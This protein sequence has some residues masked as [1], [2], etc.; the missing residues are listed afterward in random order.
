MKKKNIA[1]PPSNANLLV[2]QYKEDALR[3]E[4]SSPAHFRIQGVSPERDGGGGEGRTKEIL[5]SNLGFLISKDIKIALLVQE[6][7]QFC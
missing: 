5:R 1:P 7:W 3:P 4:L 2:F 6:L